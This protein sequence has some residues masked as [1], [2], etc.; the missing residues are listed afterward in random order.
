MGHATVGWEHAE[1]S[2]LAAVAGIEPCR[3]LDK[4]VLGRN[5]WVS[6][7]LD[8]VAEDIH[9]QPGEGVD[10]G[11]DMAAVAGNCSTDRAESMEQEGQT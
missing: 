2:I 11:E 10:G 4:V 1:E 3:N 8:M 9:S 7:A 6:R 5:L